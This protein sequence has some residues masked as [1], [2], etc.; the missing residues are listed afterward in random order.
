[1]YNI[2]NFKI[3]GAKM[4]SKELIERIEELAKIY[5]EVDKFTFYAKSSFI[6]HKNSIVGQNEIFQSVFGGYLTIIS[7]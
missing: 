6:V 4:N 3:G 7:V 2:L 5:S 1:L